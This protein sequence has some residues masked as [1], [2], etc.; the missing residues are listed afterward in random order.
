M[1]RRVTV[2]E[3]VAA[4]RRVYFDLRDATDGITPETGQGGQSPEISVNGGAWTTSGIGNLTHIGNGRYYA[5]LDRGGPGPWGQLRCEFTGTLESLGDGFP[6]ELAGETFHI[7]GGE[8]FVAGEYEIVS[9]DDDHQIMLDTHPTDGEIG[10]GGY[11]HVDGVPGPLDTIGNR[12]QTRYTSAA[13]GETPGDTVEVVACDPCNPLR[14][15]EQRDGVHYYVHADN[16]NSGLA[17]EDALATIAAGLSAV[18][19]NDTVRVA[20]RLDWEVYLEAGLTLSTRGGRL[21]F[22]HRAAIGVWLDEGVEV[23]GDFCAVEGGRIRISHLLGSETTLLISGNG[24][25]VS[26]CLTLGYLSSEHSFC[27]GIHIT[28]DHVTIENCVMY[29]HSTHLND[30]GQHNRIRK[31]MIRGVTDA[32]LD[33][34]HGSGLYENITVDEIREGKDGFRLT[35]TN[36]KHNVIV[37][38][39]MNGSVSHDATRGVEIDSNAAGNLLVGGGCGGGIDVEDN[40][41]AG[42]GNRWPRAKRLG[43]D[44]PAGRRPTG[45]I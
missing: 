28:G 29:D 5:E 39:L 23:S 15:L 38:P 13:T 44:R 10:T 6:P 17:P 25:K 34:S 37:R 2:D 9:R 22:G 1:T 12:I 19:Q 18:A 3:S 21:L 45:S 7:D 30:D 4:R 8:H 40:S 36:A 16:G 14:H 11:G 27:S 26:D 20:R 32:G 24:C 33:V 31:V 42:E 35:G 43:C 41:I